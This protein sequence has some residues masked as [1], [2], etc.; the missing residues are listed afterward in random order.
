MPEEKLQNPYEEEHD[1]GDV[2]IGRGACCAIIAAFVLILLLPPLYR[3]VYEASVGGSDAWV[4]V[5]ELFH[6]PAGEKI[7]EHFKAFEKELEDR[8]AFTEP[9][10]EA[11]QA[12]L[13]GTLREGNRKTFIGR[14]GWLFLK[15]ALDAL[16][17]YGPLVPE[18]DSVAK[19]PNRAPWGAPLEAIKTFAH[20]LDELG[21][22]LVLVPIPVKPMIYP[23]HITGRPSAAPLQHRD[24]AEFYRQI[25]A[26]PNARVIDLADEFWSKKSESQLFL[27]QDT[28]WTPEGMQLAASAL[29]QRLGLTG[30]PPWPIAP[31][32]EVESIGD[33]V[34]QLKLPG[35]GRDEYA[36]ERAKV[37]VVEGFAPD[38]AANVTLLGDSFT[39]IYSSTSLNWGEGAGFAE[40]LATKIGRPLDVIAING[41]ASTGV[42]RELA[43]RGKEHLEK[44]EL[45][46]WAIAARD[47]FLS[48]TTARQNN[49][50]WEDVAIPDIPDPTAGGPDAAPVT[51]RATL[52]AKSAV[53]DPST[54]TYKNA[55][56]T[57]E[58]RVDEVLSGTYAGETILVKHWAFRDKQLTAAGLRKP[59]TQVTLELVPFESKAALASEQGF[60]DYEEDVE[61]MLAPRY[62]AEG[63]AEAAADTDTA[64]PQRATLF[65]SV[66]CLVATLLVVALAVRLRR[67]ES[68]A[69]S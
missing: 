11:I 20:Q 31:A 66:S 38:P 46:I 30:K 19:D 7:T 27:K 2:L 35:D 47:L 17:G 26:L 21:V 18:P 8:A 62:W 68:Q 10:R 41:Q 36:P 1:T 37:G 48:E 67:R 22:E 44:K 57:C 3:N 59:D 16:T 45:I 50:E 12:A 54:V 65:A 69:D 4:P 23:E 24:A 39:N 25:E 28:H 53:V 43:K 29:A 40:H 32:T 9:P 51:L 34:E 64:N 6:K 42:R 63:E 14:D 33:L 52:L 58:Y 13:T 5:T 15:P 49:V 60:D 56:F 61:K 55:I